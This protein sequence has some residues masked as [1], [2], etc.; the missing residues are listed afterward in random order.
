MTADTIRHLM[1]SAD[2]V[3]NGERPWDIRVHDDRWYKRI[4]REKNLGLGESY[5]DGWWDCP[6]IDDMIHRV[7]SARL[8]QVIKG[9]IG[10]LLKALPAAIFNMQSRLRSRIV[11]QKHYDLGND[12]FRAFLDENLQY[13]CA[14]FDG[15]DDLETAQRKKLDLIADKLQ[16]KPGDHVLDIGCG[17]GGLARYLA[18]NHDCRVTAVNIS[19]EQLAFGRRFCEGLPVTFVDSD[20]RKLQGEFDKIVSVGMFEHVGYRNYRTFMNVVHRCLKPG[21]V[22]LLHTI[23][24][25][26]SCT[27]CDPWVTRYIFPNGMLPSAAQIGKAAEGLFVIE[28][29]HNFGPH[30]DRT[31]R[32]WNA[33]FQQAW[34]ELE[35]KYGERFKRMWEYYLLS[36][37]GAF[38]ARDIQLWQVVMTREADRREQPCCRF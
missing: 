15:T 30:Y 32:H 9:H 26:Q 37:A 22:F 24:A 2:V 13:S 36:C 35:P 7:L 12:L 6:S 31:L 19:Q 1:E 25:N 16:I 8:D 33:R 27:S 3:I 20:Y 4:W 11:A 29:W 17:W 21:G 23:G 5:M 28:D 18:M 10:Y 38:R 34:P 14:Y